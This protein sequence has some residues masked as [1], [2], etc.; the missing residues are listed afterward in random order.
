MLVS[1]RGPLSFSQDDNGELVARRGAGGLVSGLGPLVADTGT[2]WLAAAMSEA[3]R[4]AAAQGMVEAQG[5]RTRLLAIDPEIYRLAYDVVS[6]QTLW[7]VHHGL[8]DLPRTPIFTKAFRIAWDAYRRMNA[9]FADAIAE[10]APRDT[11]VLVQDY[12]LSLVG[13]DLAERRGDLLAIHFSHTPF[14]PPVWLRVLPEHVAEELLSGLAAFRSCGF[15]T[16]RWAEEFLAS[17]RELL[18]MTPRT[19]VS[20]LP[21]DPDDVRRTAASPD[22]D[23]AL[24]E[25]ATLVD[26]RVVI[27]RVDRIEL[28]KNIVRG[29][30]AFDD[31]LDRYPNWRER[32]V[33]VA[34]VYPSRGG[35]PE[36]QRYQTE[37]ETAVARV[38]QRWGTA[39]WTPIIFDTRDDYPWSVAVLRRADALLVNPLRDGLNLVAKEAALVNE[40]D[41][42]LCLSPEAGVWSELGDVA[43]RV[44]PHDIAGTADALDAA[45]HMPL[46]TRRAH[47]AELRARAERRRPADW[48]A[49]QLAAAS[50]D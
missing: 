28:S 29:F 34:S 44:Q 12:H 2:T 33:F 7:F 30:L 22:C 3:D 27:A 46:D 16:H 5:M 25:I 50:T 9:T 35:V 41:A 43:L 45:L 40:R 17:C 8:Y 37:I 48:L 42:V 18:A 15:H 14:A 10:E 24:E 20:P 11:V 39:N 21:A 32:V 4:A 49:D 38:N 31:L 6:N 47:A 13:R 19:F 23:A 1:N 26:D 36:Y